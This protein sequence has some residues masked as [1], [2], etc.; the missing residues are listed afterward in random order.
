MYGTLLACVIM[1]GHVWPFFIMYGHVWSYMVMCGKVWPCVVMYGH[2]MVMYGN[3]WSCMV[4]YDYNLLI[5][6]GL[7][8][9]EKGLQE[10]LKLKS[11][12]SKLF[13]PSAGCT[14]FLKYWKT[15]S[16]RYWVVMI[17]YS[18]LESQ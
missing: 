2:V 3:G 10:V 6:F 14:Y 5:K 7:I 12:T 8:W 4:K 9:S 13:A 18:T 17:S 15:T 1:Y 11:P 16:S